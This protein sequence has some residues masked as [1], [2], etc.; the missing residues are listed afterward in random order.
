MSKKH[1]TNSKNTWHRTIG[2]KKLQCQGKSMLINR[3]NNW[4]LAIT[5]TTC[6]YP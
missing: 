2:I 6:Q 5:Y 1:I 4:F 3:T